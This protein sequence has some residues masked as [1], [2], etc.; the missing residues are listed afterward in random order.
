MSR[1][2]PPPPYH[3]IDH[4]FLRQSIFNFTTGQRWGQGTIVSCSIEK[5]HLKYIRKTKVVGV[6]GLCSF[7]RG[8]AEGIYRNPGLL[9]NASGQKHHEAMYLS[10]ILQPSGIAFPFPVPQI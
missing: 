9:P 8:M 10:I 6:S 7:S 3:F 4:L 2:P 1:L 5:Q